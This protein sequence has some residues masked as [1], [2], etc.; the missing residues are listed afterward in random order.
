MYKI[1]LPFLFIDLSSIIA[2]QGR[3][4]VPFVVI[5]SGLPYLFISSLLQLTSWS[6]L[7]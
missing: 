4:S 2:I 7:L 6:K 1:M 5:G 3:V